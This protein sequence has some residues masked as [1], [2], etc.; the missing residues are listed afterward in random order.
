[1]IE[2]ARGKISVAD[3]KAMQADTLNISARE[4]MPYLKALAVTGDAARGREILSQWDMR[5]DAG[6]AG[7]AVYGY[8]WQALVEELFKDKFPV[9]LWNAD[10]LLESNSRLM[11]TVTTLLADPRG[12]FL[13]QARHAGRPR[14]TRRGACAGAGERNEGRNQEAGQGR[15][16]AGSGARST[17]R[18]SGTSPSGSR[19]S[20][21][22]SA[23]STGDRFPLPAACS[24]SSPPTGGRTSPSTRTSSLPCARSWTSRT[25]PPRR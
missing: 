25:F 11:N 1:M 10:S 7:A 8:F 23:S 22:W 14:D 21:R 16:A 9:A 12:A 18:S 4:V 5:M 6:S 13:G 15:R 17:R 24:R 19:G 3:V 20:S 2:G